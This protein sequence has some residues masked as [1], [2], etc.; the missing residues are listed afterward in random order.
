MHVEERRE[1]PRYGLEL[2]IRI[3]WKDKWENE[4]ETSGAT[5]NISSSGALIVCNSLIENGS[6]IDVLIK[7]PSEV[8]GTGISHLAGR[9]KVVRDVNL[10][11]PTGGLGHGIAFNSF[12]LEI[13]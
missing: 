11:I 8:A 7:L 3:R 2:P 4:R 6:G 9:G 12:G 13:V 5:V 10:S 1:N